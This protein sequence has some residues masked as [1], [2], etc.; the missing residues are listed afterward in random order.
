MPWRAVGIEDEL[1]IPCG[2]GDARSGVKQSFR[3]AELPVLI[4]RRT[5]LAG[6]TTYAA[7][8]HVNI[9]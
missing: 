3:A 9:R 4:G 7:L 5:R 2:R 1:H 8:A 6:M